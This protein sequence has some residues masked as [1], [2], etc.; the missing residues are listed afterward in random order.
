MNLTRSRKVSNFQVAKGLEGGYSLY[1]WALYTYGLHV[2]ARCLYCVLCIASVYGQSLLLSVGNVLF[3]MLL[4]YSSKFLRWIYPLRNFGTTWG[5]VETLCN[6][7]G[8][9]LS[10]LRFWLWSRFW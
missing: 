8:R 10:E 7:K 2:V 9:D 1:R 3:D 6:G 5:R 4:P